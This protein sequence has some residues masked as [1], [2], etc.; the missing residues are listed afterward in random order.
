MR[1]LK[2]VLLFFYL[3]WKI[4]E[5]FFEKGYTYHASA[6][7]F[8][9]FLTLNTGVVFFGTVLKYIPDKEVVVKK[10]YQIFP[11]V[12][13]E[14]V[15]LLVQSVENLSVKV[16]ILTLILVVFFMGNF[17]RTLELAFSYIAKVK[18]RK[19]PLVNYL[20]PFLFGFLMVFYG[21]ADLIFNI[22]LKTFSHFGFIY[23]LV[24]KILFTVRV[25]IDYLILPL[26]LLSLYLFISPLKLNFRITLA[27]SLLLTLFLNPLKAIFTWYISNFLLKNLVLTPF[28]GI[29]V[30]LIWIYTISVF[31]LFGYRVVLFLQSGGWKRVNRRA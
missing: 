6:V 13:Q 31:I 8:S 26:A 22:V 9:A 1:F 20:L 23:P 12:S 2:F 30:F 7:A 17:L 10:L 11:H 28:A 18:P 14:I 4:V 25:V 29:L 19:I 15:N 27:I 21:F 16:Q 3:I 24:L 5:D